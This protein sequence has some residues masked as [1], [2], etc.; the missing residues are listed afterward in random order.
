MLHIYIYIY[1]VC[2]CLLEWPWR[3]DWG[4]WPYER[5][6][7]CLAMPHPPA[8]WLLLKGL[9][10]LCQSSK[11]ALPGMAFLCHLVQGCGLTPKGRFPYFTGSEPHSSTSGWR[12]PAIPATH[13]Y[14]LSILHRSWSINSLDEDYCVAILV[15]PLANTVMSRNMFDLSC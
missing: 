13:A 10:S 6:G 12:I 3:A 14:D 15:V 8:V 9:Q 5:W 4:F 11:D 1:C 2:V 7:P